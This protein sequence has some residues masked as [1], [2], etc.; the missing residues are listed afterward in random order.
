MNEAELKDEGWRKQY[1]SMTARAV[2]AEA[3]LRYSVWGAAAP[4]AATPEE[5]LETCAVLA[6]NTPGP[7]W[8][9]ICRQCANG[10]LTGE[11]ITTGLCDE[12]APTR[13]DSKGREHSSDCTFDEEVVF[14]VCTCG[15]WPKP[16]LNSDTTDQKEKSS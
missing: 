10:P 4:D 8:M 13:K 15:A 14:P 16:H 12:C 2:R 9:P 7:I 1:D 5:F 6:A 11:S 3:A